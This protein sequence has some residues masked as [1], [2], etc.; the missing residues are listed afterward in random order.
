M[1]KNVFFTLCIALVVWSCAKRGSITGGEVDMYPPKIVKTTPENFSTNF[2]AK[3]IIINFDE[4]VKL[5]DVNKQL[6][7]SPP[8]KYRP[9]ITPYTA[10]KQIKIRLK[11][12][13]QPNTT[14]SFNFGQSI[15][16]N[17]EGNKL[18]GFKY[19]FST[20]SYIDS[21]SLSGNVKDALDKETQS[22]VSVLLYEVNEQF[23]DSIIY[24][25]NP[26]YVTTTMDSTTSFTLENLKEG[27]YLLVALKDQN[28][29]FRF[30]PQYDKIG[31][32]NE[33]I[34]VPTEENF[35]LELFKEVLDFKPVRAFEASNNKIV[36]AYEGHPDK[37]TIELKNGNEKLETRITQIQE[38][39]SLQ[40]WYRPIEADS[41]TLNVQNDTLEKSF[42]IKLTE[43]K[44]DTLSV[45]VKIPRTF[46][47][48]DK[49][50]VEFS[51]PIERIDSS[52]IKV[53]KDSVEIENK[54]EYHELRQSLELFFDKEE[55]QKYTF[56]MLPEAVTDFYGKSNDTL[57]VDFSTK[58]YSDY[59][60]LKV[61][62]QNVKE[63]PVII[64]LTDN[65]GKII[66][67][68][69][70]EE[71]NSVEFMYLNP[72]IYMIR[73]IYDSNKNG[74]WDTGNY[75]RKIQP[76]KVVYYP[77]PIDVRANWDIEQAFILKE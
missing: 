38:R 54:F 67:E 44:V 3:E 77:E 23:N 5:K 59:G 17:N 37:A 47:F 40:I 46:T 30:D 35:K 29:N 14:Y 60:N 62:L 56:M 32:H 6:I 55:K 4:F 11:D 71:E 63:F 9:E 7:V 15:E 68:H 25:E 34:A 22:Y 66:A 49:A 76:E 73:I 72:A 75:L 33:I 53:Y 8:L 39:D 12:T 43:K 26:R 52:K 45:S 69:Y 48:R 64:Q 1:S 2:N 61:I 28:N 24:K 21:L 20:G 27:N 50:M 41:L 70:T 18:R 74:I 16:D 31:F 42:N 57:K 10:S 58:N 19:V 51:T 13:L 36:L 65:K